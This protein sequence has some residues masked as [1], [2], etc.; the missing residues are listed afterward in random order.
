MERR[1]KRD[2][3]PNRPM[4][5]STYKPDPQPVV[6]LDDARGQRTPLDVDA[7]LPLAVCFAIWA[8]LAG[9]GWGLVYL[10]FRLI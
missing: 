10:L 1:R 9:A 4:L 6:D 8:A 2:E 5:T 7:P 3:P